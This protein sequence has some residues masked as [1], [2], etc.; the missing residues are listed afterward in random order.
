MMSYFEL[1]VLV[2]IPYA[3]LISFLVGMILLFRSSKLVPTNFNSHF[4]DNRLHAWGFGPFHLA[5]TLSIAGH[6]VA[7]FLP[8]LIL[9]WNSHPIRLYGHGIVALTCGL[10]VLFGLCVFI[11]RRFTSLRLRKR[12]SWIEWL[13]YS[14]LLLLVVSGVLSSILHPWGTSWFAAAASK[15]LWSLVTL[16]P[17]I[18]SVS[19]APWMI[20]IHMTAGFLLIGLIP[21]SNLAHLLCLPISYF[22]RPELVIHWRTRRPEAK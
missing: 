5:I 18:S 20:Q 7:L 22:W 2:A 4:L 8:G 10:L 6:L 14:L 13:V 17:D 16:N 12:T 3:G 19:G 11:V 9:S 1:F 15:Y 21:F